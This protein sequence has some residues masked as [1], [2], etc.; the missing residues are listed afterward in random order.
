[1]TAQ[2][3]SAHKEMVCVVFGVLLLALGSPGEAQQPK[4]VPRIEF[5]S[6]STSSS[7]SDRIKSFQ[8]GLREHGYENGKNIILE[9][10]FA[11]G[12]ADRLR[13]LASELVN[14]KVDVIV[15]AGPEVTR[16]AKQATSTIATVMAQ[17]NDPV[18]NGFVASLARPGGNI[19]GFS[20]M[21]PEIVGKQMELLKESIPRLSRVAILGNLSRPGTQ[22]ELKNLELVARELKLQLNVFDVPIAIDIETAF[23]N[24]RNERDGAVLGLTNAALFSQRTRVAELALKNHL[25]LIYG[26]HEWAEAGALMS[27]GTNFE[28]LYRRVATYVDKILKGAKPAELPVEQPTKFEFV[29]NLR[30]AKQIGLTIPPN[31]LLRADKV[32]K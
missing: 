5:L 18:G 21:A 27:Y 2:R 7:Y 29:I 6:A 19:T 13:E 1:V 30:T 4:K 24:A 8:Q 12:N 25:P 20:Q 17:D 9:Y 16:A 26:S 32:I 23:R 14:L 15:T 11:E 22:Q 10:K 3:K 31:V 28:D